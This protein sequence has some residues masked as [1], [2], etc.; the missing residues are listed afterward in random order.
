MSLFTSIDVDWWIG[1]H[2]LLARPHTTKNNSVFCKIAVWDSTGWPNV[3]ISDVLTSSLKNLLEW[4]SDVHQATAQ[5]L[6]FLE[7][8]P[9]LTRLHRICL[10]NSTKTAL[11]KCICRSVEV[12]FIQISLEPDP[13]YTQPG[14]FQTESRSTFSNAIKCNFFRESVRGRTLEVT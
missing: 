10:R 5:P 2:S 4:S 6:V 12:D 3:H 14:S 1:N 9:S 8:A 7:S 13:Q 11:G